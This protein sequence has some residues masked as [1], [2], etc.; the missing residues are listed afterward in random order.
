MKATVSL[1]DINLIYPWSWV[2][3]APEYKVSSVAVLLLSFQVT[4]KENKMVEKRIGMILCIWPGK[5]R[6]VK[7]E[8]A[9]SL[10]PFARSKMISK[11]YARPS[12]ASKFAVVWPYNLHV[13]FSHCV[14]IYV[15]NPRKVVL[16]EQCEKQSNVKNKLAKS[17]SVLFHYNL[18][19]SMS[20]LVETCFY[21][22]VAHFPASGE[23]PFS[24]SSSNVC[25][26]QLSWGTMKM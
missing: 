12:P 14:Y 8:H 24:K 22:W 9:Y 10:S 20:D 6:K 18:A 23:A 4:E 26:N 19:Y 11:W 3:H 7:K 5:G 16:T 17:V 15:S 1:G 25:C 13:C 2:T 21:S